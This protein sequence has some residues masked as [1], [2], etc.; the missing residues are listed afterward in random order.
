MTWSD[1]TPRNNV[2]H[3][4]LPGIQVLVFNICG[5]N[6]LVARCQQKV[7]FVSLEDIA[8]PPLLPEFIRPLAIGWRHKVARL[9]VVALRVHLCR[10]S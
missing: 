3:E 9:P 7:F 2:A 10:P 6:I 4:L 8:V 5:E 1:P